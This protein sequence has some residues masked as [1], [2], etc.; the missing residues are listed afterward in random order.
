MECSLFGT[1]P[2]WDVIKLNVFFLN[3]IKIKW[4]LFGMCP[5]WNLLQLNVLFLKCDQKGMSPFWNVIKM[6]CALFRMCRSLN[7]TFLECTVVRL[8][9][10]GAFFNQIG[11]FK[12]CLLHIIFGP[13]FP[14]FRLKT[15]FKLILKKIIQ[16]RICWAPCFQTKKGML[17]LDND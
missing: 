12:K 11:L 13:K 3:M 4:V 17:F 15:I 14:H 8:T 10:D 1:C 6:K 5:F 2:F 9:T 7:V 16:I